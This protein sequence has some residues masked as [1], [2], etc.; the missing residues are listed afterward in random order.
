MKRKIITIMLLAITLT[1]CN[2]IKKGK[3]VTDRIGPKL[4]EMDSTTGADVPTNTD[5]T[6][7]FEIKEINEEAVTLAEI[8][9]EENLYTY[10]IKDLPNEN[11]NIGNKY[12]ITWDGITLNSYPAQF[13][14]VK[15]IESLEN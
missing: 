11:P 4:E 12:R 7:D 1:S 8:G 2:P 14:E 9:N 13:G 6:L 5:T 3:G 15:T 10:P